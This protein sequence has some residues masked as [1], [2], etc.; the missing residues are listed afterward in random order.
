MVWHA[1]P[2][3]PNQGS[4]LC[5]LNWEHEV[6]TTEPQRKS[7]DHSIFIQETTLSTEQS[8]GSSGQSL[9]NW[10]YFQI[11][12]LKLGSVN[13]L[14]Q[15]FHRHFFFK[16]QNTFLN[17]YFYKIKFLLKD[18]IFIILLNISCNLDHGNHRSSQFQCIPNRIKIYQIENKVFSKDFSTCWSISQLE[19]FLINLFTSPL[20]FVRININISLFANFVC[21]NCSLL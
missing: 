3:F 18:V 20:A 19:H 15:T 17:K 5:P 8:T 6:L 7:L 2:Q 4:N 14:T 10:V 12:T 1:G 16:S 11:W 13:I 9:P 21:N